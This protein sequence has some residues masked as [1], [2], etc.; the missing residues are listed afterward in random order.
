MFRKFCSLF[1]NM[2]FVTD[3]RE[4]Q[5]LLDACSST[6]EWETNQDNRSYQ[7]ILSARECRKYILS[8]SVLTLNE[9]QIKKKTDR[10]YSLLF[11]IDAGG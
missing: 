4:F 7:R 10:Y 6:Q 1:I 8:E 3:V 11:T 2:A 5:A 9:K